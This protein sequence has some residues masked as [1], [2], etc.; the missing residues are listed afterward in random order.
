MPF[1]PPPASAGRRTGRGWMKN[2]E[3]ASCEKPSLEVRGATQGRAWASG[4]KTKRKMGNFHVLLTSRPDGRQQFQDAAGQTGISS[5][6]GWFFNLSWREDHSQDDGAAQESP[7]AMRPGPDQD[8]SQESRGSLDKRWLYTLLPTRL[9]ACGVTD[10]TPH[11]G[12]CGSS[13]PRVLGPS[14][15]P[16]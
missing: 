16:S 8:H 13:V 12:Q 10:P 4:G 9:A 15:S 14:D 5:W 7:R 3:R 6:P 11:L 1:S 2:G